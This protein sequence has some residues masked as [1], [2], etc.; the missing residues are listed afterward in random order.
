MIDTTDLQSALKKQG[1][2]L[3]DVLYVYSVDKGIVSLDD[4]PDDYVHVFTRDFV[5]IL[6]QHNGQRCFEAVP[7][8]WT[9]PKQW[10][11][12]ETMKDE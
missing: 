11:V 6:S 12:M 8:Q 7:R 4:A 10:N 3:N 5:Y 2:N 9:Q 1:L